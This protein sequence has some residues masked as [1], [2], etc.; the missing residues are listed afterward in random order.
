MFRL[1]TIGGF[2]RRYKALFVLTVL[3]AII[4]L[5]Y[6][7]TAD[8]PEWFPFAGAL[9]TLLDTLGLAII[10][11]CIFCYFQIYLPECREH[12]RVEPTVSFSVSKILTLI[13]D[14]YERMYRQKTGR[15]LR[16]DEI[17]EDELKKL[18]DGID[19]KGDLGYRFID[20]N[21]K[22]TS[23]PTYWIVNKHIEDIRVE[24]ELLI[25]LFGKYLDAELISLL[26]EIH[27]C[28][29]FTSITKFHHSGLLDKLASIGP[30][31]ELVPVQQLYRRLEK[32]VGE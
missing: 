23:V 21:S 2:I 27:R 11:N 28:S 5:V 13:A 10:A 14:P 32:Y 25:G 4:A 6:V 19:P 9:F 15:D 30:S 26:M 29:Y 18:L 8:L 1:K 16:F 17:P 12:E 7:F 20:T 22:L 31:E 3:S 24:I